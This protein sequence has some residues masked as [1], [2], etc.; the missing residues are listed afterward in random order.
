MRGFWLCLALCLFMSL[1]AG[2]VAAADKQEINAGYRSLVTWQPER[3]IRIDVS[4]W[5]PTSR[6]ARGVEVG[7]W[8]FEATQRAAPLP[9][10]W[11]LL[12]LS[13]D[14]NGSRFVYNDL[15]LALVRRGFV[16]AAPTHEWDN[17]DDMR[18]LFTADEFPARARQLSSTIDLV[19]GDAELGPVIAPDKIGVIAFGS[20]ATAPLLLAGAR[21]SPAALPGYCQAQ[22][23]DPYCTP[24]LSHKLST[25]AQD[26]LRQKEDFAKA[27]KAHEDGKIAVEKAAAAY[28][29]AEKRRR[30]NAPPLDPFVPPPVPPLPEEPDYTDS[31]VKAMALVAPGMSMVFDAASL[32]GLT[33]PVLIV[34]AGAD[35][36]N[37]V[38]LQAKPLRERIPSTVWSL[39]P[40]A[41]VL[42]FLAPCP[43]DLSQDL[44]DLCNSVSPEARRAALQQLLLELQRFFERF[45]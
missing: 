32:Q 23:K 41:G 45:L 25:L 29:E 28:K 22:S 12:V 5:Y 1:P 4:V 38:D 40:D 44:P 18:L 36:L 9:G 14:F 42:A 6:P 24:Y 19:L 34:A 27:V 16:V 21:L 15:A 26:M 2:T 13:H 3:Q 30:R 8:T 11:P 43:P 35:P 37:T 7:S 17:M 10:P 31:R 39:L 33:L 20:T